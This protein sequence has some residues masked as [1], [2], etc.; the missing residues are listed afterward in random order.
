M[1]AYEIQ[2]YFLHGPHLPSFCSSSSISK[3]PGVLGV[4]VAKLLDSPW[5]LLLSAFNGLDGA[6]VFGSDP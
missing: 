2:Q 1:E 3:V 5:S 6:D 4:V